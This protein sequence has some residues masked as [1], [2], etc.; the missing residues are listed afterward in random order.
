MKNAVLA[1]TLCLTAT[2]PVIAQTQTRERRSMNRVQ[3]T[4]EPPS[5][6]NRSVDNAKL[7]N[8]SDKQKTAVD[9]NSPATQWGNTAIQLKPTPDEETVALSGALENR[10]GKSAATQRSRV[11]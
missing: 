10:G 2:V 7:E 5:A 9:K 3:Q 8:H 11:T 1:F 6:G 4:S